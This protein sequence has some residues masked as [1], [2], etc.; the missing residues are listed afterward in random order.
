MYLCNNGQ[1]FAKNNPVFSR[2]VCGRLAW[3]YRYGEAHCRMMA[4]RLAGHS[5]Y[6]SRHRVFVPQVSPAEA[7]DLGANLLGNPNHC[8]IKE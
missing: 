6:L 8:N 3:S 7:R 5:S 4:L 2:N 1:E